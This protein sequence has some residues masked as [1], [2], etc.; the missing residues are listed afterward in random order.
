MVPKSSMSSP[1]SQSQAVTEAEGNL[2][3][4]EGRYFVLAEAT[5]SAFLHDLRTLLR[6]LGLEKP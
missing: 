4:P 2:A 6:F 1:M 5:A 3:P